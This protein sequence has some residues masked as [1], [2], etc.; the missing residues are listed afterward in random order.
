MLCRVAAVDHSRKAVG[1]LLERVENDDIVFAVVSQMVEGADTPREMDKDPSEVHAWQSRR[2]SR[3]ERLVEDGRAGGRVD[4]DAELR[5]V[6]EAE[7]ER[8][9]LRVRLRRR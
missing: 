5:A 1:R 2:S 4:L 3:R 9:D 7:R 8:V 6:G